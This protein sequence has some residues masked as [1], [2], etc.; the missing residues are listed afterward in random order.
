MAL[1]SRK[2]TKAKVQ[3]EQKNEEKELSLDEMGQ[4]SGGF[5]LREADTVETTDIDDNTRSKV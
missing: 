3:S 2:E 1:I 5:S 4:V